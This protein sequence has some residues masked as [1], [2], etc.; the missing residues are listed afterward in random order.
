MAIDLF[1]HLIQKTNHPTQ[2][3]IM[4][5][6]RK[7]AMTFWRNRQAKKPSLD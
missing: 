3:D 2:C 5:P 1:F 6:K 4:T 7:E